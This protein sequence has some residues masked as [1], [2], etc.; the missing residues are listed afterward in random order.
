MMMMMIMMM[1]MMMIMKRV[2][3]LYIN[4]DNGDVTDVGMIP[5]CFFPIIM[6][7]ISRLMVMLLC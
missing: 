5:M 4:S 7:K 2:K 3:P 6:T 1:M